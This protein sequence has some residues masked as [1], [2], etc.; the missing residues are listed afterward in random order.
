[1]IT[2]GVSMTINIKESRKPQ[3]S[4][5][6]GRKRGTP[7]RR[8]APVKLDDVAKEKMQTLMNSECLRKAFAK[9]IAAGEM[10][11][12]E[13]TLRYP[14]EYA[15]SYRAKNLLTEN[16]GMTRA[17]AFWLAEDPKRIEAMRSKQIRTFATYTGLSYELSRDIATG[18]LSL[19]Q[20]AEHDERW[21]FIWGRARQRIKA[22]KDKGR[23]VTP[24]EA[25]RWARGDFGLPFDDDEHEFDIEARGDVIHTMYPFMKK[26][27]TRRM[28]RFNLDLEGLAIVAPANCGWGPRALDLWQRY[29]AQHRKFIRLMAMMNLSDDEVDGF[30]ART[31]PARDRYA[32]YANSKRRHYF[33]LYKGERCASFLID[34]NPF[35]WTLR[36][37]D[38]DEIIKQSKLQV[39]FF[40]PDDAKGAIF[41]QSKRDD[42][43][44][45]KNLNAALAAKDRI[46]I[47]IINEQLE[48]ASK[49][50][51]QINIKLRNGMT[52]IGS[53]E[54]YS[55]F[56]VMLRL[57]NDA[58]IMILF[59][60]IYNIES[61]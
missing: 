26:R 3:N 23:S 35:A 30:I 8:P 55:P 37:I 13:F 54:W 27:H 6:R 11:Y 9:R 48:N 7:Q 25:I 10:T 39:L 45:E 49:K 38:C 41:G 44:V 29:P 53:P 46:D 60:A 47:G 24:I 22:L 18:Q 32:E 56:E 61:S 57:R 40:C 2:K 5:N 34:T 16:P 52:F 12:A 51:R 43:I 19:S 42:D 59:H 21:A 50:N 4:K 20:L 31:N 28:A 36:D 58:W 15:I 1:M 33:R 14:S 17:R